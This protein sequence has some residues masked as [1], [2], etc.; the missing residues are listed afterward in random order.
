ML[1]DS[2]RAKTLE[3]DCREPSINAADGLGSKFDG[4]SRPIADFAARQED[5]L[6]ADVLCLVPY[7]TELRFR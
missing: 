6:R 5:L 1:T 3:Y 7:S 4:Q 2:G